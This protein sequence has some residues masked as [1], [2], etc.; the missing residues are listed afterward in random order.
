MKARQTAAYPPWRAAP[1]YTGS[2]MRR[3]V[4]L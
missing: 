1:N 3:T 4:E 2:Y